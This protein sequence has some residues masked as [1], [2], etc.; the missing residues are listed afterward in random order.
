MKNKLRLY[1]FLGWFIGT[2]SV[3]NKKWSEQRNATI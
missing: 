3:G 1:G 2:V